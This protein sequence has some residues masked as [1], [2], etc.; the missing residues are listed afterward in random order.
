MFGLGAHLPPAR[1]G[2]QGPEALL[3]QGPDDQG[4]YDQP[5][6]QP[7]GPDEPGQPGQGAPHQPSQSES[8][9]GAS[10]HTPSNFSKGIF[11][12]FFQFWRKNASTVKNM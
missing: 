4:P 1:P 12:D 11:P 10:I 2:R 6:D 7:D 8:T 3:V 5:A 9:N